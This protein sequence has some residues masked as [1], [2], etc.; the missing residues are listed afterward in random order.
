[1]Q[2]RA[3]LEPEF[4]VDTGRYFNEASDITGSYAFGR[5]VPVKDE[6]SNEELD[7]Q[8][9]ALSYIMTGV[10]QYMTQHYDAALDAYDKALA[11]PNWNTD[12]GKEIVYA[13]QG[14]AYMKL[15]EKSASSCDRATTLANTES[16][17]A[18]YNR[19]LT[20]AEGIDSEKFASAAEAGLTRAYAGLANTYAVRALWMPEANDGCKANQLDVGTLQQADSYVTLYESHFHPED[21]NSGVRRKLL[22]TALQV[23]FLLWAQ[24]V[25]QNPDTLH[26]PDNPAYV[27]FTE[28]VKQ[29][30][31]GYADRTDKTW[32]FPVM[33][34]HIFSGQAHYARGELGDAID[35]YNAALAIY[36]DPNNRE[37]LSPARAMT[38]YGWRGD[39]KLRLGN[40]ADASDDYDQA[41]T[42]AISLENASAEARYRQSRQNADDQLIALQTSAAPTGS[43]EA[44]ATA[45]VTEPP[46]AETATPEVTEAP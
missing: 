35:D 18:A 26:D 8:I 42:L 31:A 37:L 10:F 23:R 41:L 36:D 16:A 24:Q 17:E 2:H 34:A 22:L 39:A 33:E 14:N 4:Y 30:I 38:T 19:S 43:A 27:A 5:D 7:A 25:V 1:M 3:L 13:L 15:A 29:T 46:P 28:I 32:A 45:A 9:T 20:V 12:D 21:F 44:G 40:Y 6:G 11:V